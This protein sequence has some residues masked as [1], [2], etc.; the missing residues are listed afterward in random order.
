MKADIMKI[1]LILACISWL[2]ISWCTNVYKFGTS[3]FEAPY[4][5]EIVHGI[6]VVVPPF[7]VVSCWFSFDETTGE[8]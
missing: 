1:I 6:G 8:E 7:S 5:R 4:A 2:P 3:D